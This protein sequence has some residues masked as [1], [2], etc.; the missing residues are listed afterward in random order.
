MFQSREKIKSKTN[1][2]K[3]PHHFIIYSVKYK[4]ARLR[5]IHAYTGC[6]AHEEMCTLFVPQVYLV[7]LNLFLK[8]IVSYTSI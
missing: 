5:L 7:V 1:F 8:D 3:T 6:Q 4:R 2:R